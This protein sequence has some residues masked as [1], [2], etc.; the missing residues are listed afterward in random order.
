MRRRK[1]T[2]KI[3]LG[4]R[5]LVVEIIEAK[6]L[7]CMCV[8]LVVKSSMKAR[9]SERRMAAI[10]DRE[11]IDAERRGE[12]CWVMQKGPSACKVKNG[13]E[14]EGRATVNNGQFCV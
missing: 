14:N 10:I 7:V 5:M 8:I 6:W 1:S 3:E 12:I 13:K 2:R 11:A 9:K 4:W